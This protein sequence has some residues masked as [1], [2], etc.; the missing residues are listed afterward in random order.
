MGRLHRVQQRTRDMISDLSP[1][2]LYDL[3]L[4]PALQWLVVYLRGHD[5]LQVELDGTVEENL[6]STDLRVLVFKLVREML[7]NV[8]KHAAV[9]AAVVRI[10]GDHSRL[11]VEV[12]DA[13][14]GFAWDPDNLVNPRRGFGCGASP[15]ASP[16]LA[17][18]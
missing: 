5:Q 11:L 9:S 17:G 7:R 16:K 4:L 18:S 6:V 1:P 3:G 2:G 13:G 10:S 15:P 14:R 8:V 12:R